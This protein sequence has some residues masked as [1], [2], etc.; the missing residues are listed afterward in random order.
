MLAS[1]EDGETWRTIYQF[2]HDR[3]ILPTY[4]L[5]DGASAIT[6]AGESVYSGDKES[7]RLMCYSHVHSNLLNHL[8]SITTNSKT[9]ADQLLRDIENLQWS[10]LNEA[11]FKKCCR[12]LEQKYLGK[13]D[14][15]LN[16]SLNV[17]F[18][19]L[20]SVWI[21]SKVSKWYEG[22]HPWRICNNQGIE[23]TNKNIKQNYTF[24]RKLELG[25]LIS[26]M[27]DLV[28]DWSEADDKLLE[29]SRL[30][31]LEGEKDSL[32]LKTAGYHWFMQNKSGTDKIIRINPAGKY[33][34]SESKEF[35]LGKVINIWAVNSSEGLKSGKSLKD[36]AKERLANREL[37]LGNS[38]DDYMRIRTSCWLLEE[39]DGDFYCDCPIGMKVRIMLLN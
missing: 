6:S 35:N 20:H 2:L 9:V 30:A 24:R 34:V 12:L 21:D 19:Y 25:E 28:K 31:M 38:F 26:V 10:A 16:A 29:S 11:T 27:L 39:R 13:Y 1:H 7:I 4:H 8:K 36:R 22:S 3:D 14:E 17:F 15:I 33:T 32:S 5:G 18:K 23:G 37:P